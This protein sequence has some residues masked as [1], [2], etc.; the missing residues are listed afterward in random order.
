MAL[1]FMRRHKRW[2][3]GFLW[4]V[5]AAFIILYIPAFQ[6]AL[7]G[8]PSEVLGKVGERT[9]TV[10]E[11]QRGYQRQRLYFERMSQGHRLDPETLRRL[12]LE[13]QVFGSLVEQRLVELEAKRLGI[14]ISDAA[15]ARA[16]ATSPDFQENGRFMGAGEIRRR[17][18]LQG[19]STEEFEE[20]LRARLLR[21]Q[22]EGLLTDG[23][24]VSDTELLREFHRRTD[25]VKAEYVLVP[26]AKYKA[27][28]ETS[29]AKIKAR[30]DAHRDAYR[31]PER[32]SV[33]Y[34]LVDNEALRSGAAVTDHEI[35][36]YYQ[37]HQDEFRQEEQSC[38]SHILVKV[39]AAGAEA[40][41]HPEPEAKAL[42][43]KLLLEVK[44]G[45]DF[46][47]IAR[48][49]SEDQGSAPRGG[50]LDCFPR[51]RMVTE[52]DNAVAN[53]EPGQTSDLVKTPFGYHIIRL[54]SR[55]ED[56]VLPLI[57]VKD[58]VKTIVARQ[59]SDALSAAKSEA[60]AAALA[61]GRSLAEAAKAAGLVVEKSAAFSRAEPIAPLAS[62]ALVARVFEMKQG[63]VEKEGFA[64]A[65]GTAFV[66]LEE[67]VPSRLPE[68]KEV[69]AQVKA[70]VI[71]E[72]SMARARAVAV[73]LA[74]HDGKDGLEKA[75]KAAGLTRK[76]TPV[77]TSRGQS[78]GDLG[79]GLAVEEVAFTLEPGRLSEPVRTR[80]GF[81]VLRVLERKTG[82]AAAF[83]TQKA[84]IAQSLREQKGAQLLRAFL[85]ESRQRYTVERSQAAFRRVA[86][87]E[88]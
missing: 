2:L 23:T 52:F 64:V 29:E 66:G 41:G 54:T 49:A 55:R 77:L 30:F 15:V 11:F 47:A 46:A 69:E 72:E 73:E 8:S 65:R 84:G 58:R 5:I 17:L 76:E 39:K 35:D 22:L 31:I 83:E 34:L 42:A 78:L 79:A 7:A 61:R 82:D 13:E 86:G 74:T 56:S 14:S 70:D 60:I 12:G 59:K 87:L 3:Y 48:R 16:L 6:G 36:L 27:E 44:A 37:A 57:Q 32:R 18:Q 75:A 67:I 53:L 45:G 26:A 24:T 40:E 33:S 88:R 25:Q 9:I 81:A 68:L 51:G 50:D 62:P 21:E 85:A 1:G 80:D 63:A 19:V 71:A 38:A 20:S 4:L 10:G 28:A 43:Q